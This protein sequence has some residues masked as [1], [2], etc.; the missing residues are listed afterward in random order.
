M[1]LHSLWIDTMKRC[2]K[3]LVLALPAAFVAVLMTLALPAM[4]QT[5]GSDGSLGVRQFPK[6][7]LRGVLVVKVPPEV[8]LNGKPDRLSPGARIRNLN[9]NFVTP[10]ALIGQELLVNYTRDSLG[11][12]YEVWMLSAEEAK[13]KRA[14]LPRSFS[15]GFESSAAPQDD[16]KTPYNQLPRYKQ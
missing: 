16:G 7:A 3:H 2:L 6:A 11:Q 1:L 13:E 8:S 14:G 5:T 9:N 4:S 10:G 12:L 15:F